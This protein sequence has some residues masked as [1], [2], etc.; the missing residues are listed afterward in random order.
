MNLERGLTY[1]AVLA[2]VMPS[3][4]QRRALRKAWRIEHALPRW[5]AERSLPELMQQLDA[6]AAQPRTAVDAPMLVRIADAAVGLD[7]RSPLGLCLRR[8]L[9]RYVLLRS[10]GVPVIVQFGAKKQG[11]PHD[12]RIAGHAWLTLDGAPY[13]ERPDDYRGFTAIYSYPP[14][15]SLQSC[16]ASPVSST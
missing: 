15:H 8:S 6:A 14:I 4:V 16:A 12:I 7:Y 2:R 1:L 3:A 5:F 10:A 9:V 13:A 11:S